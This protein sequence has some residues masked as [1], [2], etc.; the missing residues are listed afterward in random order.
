MQQIRHSPPFLHA[1][2]IE[3]KKFLIFS[4]FGGEN[5]SGGYLEGQTSWGQILV[6]D[7]G[8]PGRI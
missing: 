6:G 8:N 3:N 4:K 5:V 2:K 1:T 7:H